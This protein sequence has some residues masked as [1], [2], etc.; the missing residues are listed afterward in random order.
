MTNPTNLHDMNLLKSIVTIALPSLLLTSACRRDDYSEF[1]QNSRGDMTINLSGQISQEYVTRANDEGFAH[2]DVMGVYVVDYEGN[3]PGTLLA[4]GNHGDNVRHTYDAENYRWDSA[5]DLYWKDKH[6]RIDI[7]GYYPF[8][9][10]EDVN[11]YSFTVKTDQ[12][13]V[14]DDGTMGNYE[15]SDFLW[16]KV[17]GVEPTDNVIRLPMYHRMANARVTLVEG[18][19]F[20]KGEWALLKKQV[21]VT[22]TVQTSTID[23]STGVVTPGKEV[24]VNS[25]IPA[26]RGDEWRAIVVP[27]TISAGTQLFSISIDG[28]AYKFSKNEEI[29]YVSG[30]MNNFSIR[31]DR[32]AA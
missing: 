8:G 27:Q 10:P 31:V 4:N 12:S 18:D 24:G 13:I 17:G 9:S 26:V 7:Y 11:A 28:L 25:I 30:K 21:L 15:A 23:L 2:G 5:Y 16:G 19:G 6:T 14:P 20:G 29:E 1:A 3:N 32:K 22:N